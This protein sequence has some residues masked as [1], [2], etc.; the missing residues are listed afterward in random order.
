MPGIKALRKILIGREASTD[1][2]TEV[3]A[4]TYLRLNGTIADMRE[5]E[6]PEED[7]GLLSGT[8][9]SYV[10][11]LSGELDIEGAA[12]FEQL[13]YILEMGVETATPTQD[14]AGSGYVYAYALPI[15]AVNT[16]ATR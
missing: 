12:T 5:R 1:P 6:F 15:D 13:P 9:R 4:T 14:G 7:I 2:G 16:P 3:D 11:K 10:A 8:D